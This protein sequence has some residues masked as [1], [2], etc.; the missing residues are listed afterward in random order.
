[1][2]ILALEPYYGGSHR[3]FLDG[4]SD[5]SRHDWTVLGLPPHKWKWRMRH[6]AVTLAEQVG[7]FVADNAR[8]DLV[9]CSDML[10]LAEFRGLAPAAPAQLPGVAYFHEN[11]LTYPVPVAE[12]RDLHFGMINFT[13]ALAATQVWFNSGFHRDSFLGALEDL[14]RRMPDYNALESID[15]IRSKSYVYPQGIA[16]MP[17]GRKRRPGP[18]HLLWAAR[19]EYDKNPE[20]F[21]NVLYRLADEGLPFKVSVVGERFRETPVVFEQARAR[22]ADRVVRWGYLESRADYETTLSEA[23]IVVSTA[24]HEFFG[25][26]VIEAVAAG[27]FP[28]LPRRLAY[29]ELFGESN[30]FFYDGTEPGLASALRRLVHVCVE[31]RLWG[32]DPDLGRRLVEPYVWENLVPR[33]DSALEDIAAT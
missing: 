22:L 17:E 12:E 26:S 2:R 8:F 27:A 4:W 13:T 33:L 3:A 15:A 1:M 24:D 19:W 10:N 9:F 30:S 32:G 25:V 14:L 16:R 6:A 28:L 23:D 7:E 31:D 21:F 18:P 5:A 20:M 29:P 11:Q